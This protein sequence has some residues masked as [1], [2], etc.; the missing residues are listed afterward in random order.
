[1]IASIKSAARQPSS[2]LLASVL[3]TL[4][5]GLFAVLTIP[6]IQREANEL[7]VYVGPDLTPLLATDGVLCPG[8]E[9]TYNI[10]VTVTKANAI[11]TVYESW[12]TPGLFCPYGLGFEESIVGPDEPG[13][14]A[15]SG[16]ARRIVPDLPPGQWELRH[17]NKTETAHNGVLRTTFSGY[18]VPFTVPVGCD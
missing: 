6:L 16:V 17:R 11:V 2:W 10:S 18:R 14:A 4:A 1:M 5:L 13:G 9:L 7:V 8:D 15:F 12:C 3:F